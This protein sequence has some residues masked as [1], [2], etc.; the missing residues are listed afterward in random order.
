MP[1]ST[2]KHEGDLY[3]IRFI[4]ELLAEISFTELDVDTLVELSRKHYDSKCRGLS[5]RGG[6]LFGMKNLFWVEEGEQKPRRATCKLSVR[7]LDTLCKVTQDLSGEEAPNLHTW[8]SRLL[9]D[10]R[11]RTQELNGFSTKTS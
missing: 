10:V 7:D 3:R 8:F 9:E 6:L 2:K 5:K 11:K 4:T 1:A